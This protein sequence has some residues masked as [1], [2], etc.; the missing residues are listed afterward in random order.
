MLFNPTFQE[1]RVR[2]TYEEMRARFSV[3]W[4]SKDLS[5]LLRSRLRYRWDD[6]QQRMFPGNRELP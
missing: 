4:L 6:L 1:A 3:P 2:G 5:T